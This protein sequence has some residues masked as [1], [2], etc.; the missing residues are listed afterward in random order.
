MRLYR[1]RWSLEEIMLSLREFRGP[2]EQNGD[3]EV[4][5]EAFTEETENLLRL[6]R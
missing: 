1:M 4:A 6:P 3:T 5:W 2:H